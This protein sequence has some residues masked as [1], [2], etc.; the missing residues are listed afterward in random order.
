MRV[1]GEEERE[2][3]ANKEKVRLSCSA[4]LFRPILVIASVPGS[5]FGLIASASIY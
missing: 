1:D 2:E 5:F 3:G 4:G